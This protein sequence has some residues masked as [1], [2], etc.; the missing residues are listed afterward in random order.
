MPKKKLLIT[1]VC[2]FIGFNLAT[3]IIKNKKFIVIGLDN[4]NDYYDKKLKKD[5][6]AIL[7]KNKNFKFIKVD[8]SKNNDLEKKLRNF[9]FFALYHLAAQAGVRYSFK[10]P[11]TYLDS[12]LVGFFNILELI[13]RKKPKIFI[14]ASSSSVYGN[15]K[16]SAF[17]ETDNTDK[18]LSFYAATKKSNEVMAYSYSKL[19][20]I[21]TVCIRF[22][23]VYGP[24]G[25]P[26]MAIYTFFKNV[27][28]GKKIFLRD[29]GQHLRD[30]TFIK[31]TVQ[32]L[33]CFIEEKN[34]KKIRNNFEIFNIGNSNTTSTINLLKLIIKIVKKVPKKIIYQKSKGESFKTRAKNSKIEKFS[35]IKKRTNIKLGIKLFSDWYKQ[36]YNFK[37]Y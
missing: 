19:Y 17:S 11:R 13:K 16:K 22:F 14:F 31:D 7:K 28:S 18:P 5:R 10:N 9:N 1:G 32:Y 27:L 26:D 6:L 4:I 20:K 37:D 21:K 33:L 15:S 36:Y 8:I 34:I 12:N 30:Y 23:S 3:E 24:Y 35:K 25:R 2:G 29:K